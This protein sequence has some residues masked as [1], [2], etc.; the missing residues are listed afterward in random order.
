MLKLFRAML[1]SLLALGA[2]AANG[3]ERRPDVLLITVDTLRA[4]YLSVYGFLHQTSPHIAALAERGVVF[5]RAIASS[6][7]TVPS[8]A[9]IFTSR[10]VRGHS[11]GYANGRTALVGLPTLAESFRD[12]GYST[13]AFVSN[14]MLRR[15]SGLDRGFDH[16]DDEL[17]DFER[18][19]AI[20]ERVAEQ[21][22]ER[23]LAWIGRQ[24]EVPEFLWV[25]YQD[26]H[27]PYTPP[28]ELANRF[29]VPADRYEK[30]LPVLDHNLGLDGIPAY[31]AIVGLDLPSQYKGRYAG[32]IFHADASIGRLLEAVRS[33]RPG[34]IVLLTSDHG[35]SFGE[36][37]RYL[38]HGYTTTPD[39]AHVPF[40]LEAPGIEPGRRREPVSHVDVMPTLLELAGVPIPEAAAGTALGPHLRAEREP[41]P[42]RWVYCDIGREL[43][44]Y[45][46]DHFVR[47]LGVE[48]PWQPGAEASRPLWVRH[49]WSRSTWKRSPGGDLDEAILGYSENVVPMHLA[50]LSQ[51][52]IEMLR[53]LG[54]SAD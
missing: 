19:R 20:P 53:S 40:I 26:P 2:A 51:P 23:V 29:D 34:T 1:V 47:L 3:G 14:I 25:H 24:S 12:A 30:R 9:S 7:A 43:S 8:H 13:A 37:S 52:S 31:Q 27:G 44:A 46:S 50:E 49:D 16:Y 45:R 35:E 6:G 32:E 10:Y 41:L 38:V 28:E 21:T 5:E 33:R 18:N 22:T 15:V 39:V 42:E 17:P 36:N 11:V 54:Y 4:D 48:G